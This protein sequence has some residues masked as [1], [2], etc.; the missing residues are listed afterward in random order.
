MIAEE[1]N[2]L[3]PGLVYYDSEG[4]PEG[5]HYEWLGVPLIVEMKKLRNRVEALE[6]QLKQNPT[7]A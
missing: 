6:N 2:E 7:A 5:V 3:Y 1:V 4:K